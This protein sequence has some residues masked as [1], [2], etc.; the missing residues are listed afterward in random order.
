VSDNL[1]ESADEGSTPAKKKRKLTKAAEAKLK[2]K[3][4]EKA[5][6]QK[7]K[8]KPDQDE[9]A[10]EE[11]DPYKAKSKGL[12]SSATGKPPPIGT[13]H[14]CADCQKKFTVVSMLLLTFLQSFFIPLTPCTQTKYTISNHAGFLCHKCAKSSGADPFKKAA[15]RKRKPATEKRTIKN[16]EE[17]EP[18]KSLTGMC[19]SVC[20]L[21]RL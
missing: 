12:M 13:F 18:I 14:D 8:G 10:D 2:A 4:K 16:F 3:E 6:L 21:L 20:G 7:K 11:E 15:P 9:E 5:S 17:T 1:D 19:I